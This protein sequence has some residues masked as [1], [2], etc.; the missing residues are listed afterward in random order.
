[1]DLCGRA[2]VPQGALVKA[3]P[4]MLKGLALD[5]YYSSC[6]GRYGNISDLF[7]AVEAYFENDD[8][9]RTVLSQ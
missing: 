2:D 8:S 3:F 7:Q 4:T 1:M 9:K 6:R 5:C